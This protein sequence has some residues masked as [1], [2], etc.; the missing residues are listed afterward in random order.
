MRLPQT[1]LSAVIVILWAGIVTAVISQSAVPGNARVQ[2]AVLPGV[3]AALTNSD[4]AAVGLATLAENPLLDTAAQMKANDMLQN[5]YYAHTSPSGRSPFYW[6]D[7]VG[8]KYLNVG[9]NLDLVYSGTDATVNADWMNSV[10]HRTNILLP[11]FTETGS[12]VASG[13]YEGNQVTFV[14]ELFATP[15]P[16]VTEPPISPQVSPVVSKS[17]AIP[18]A[19]APV[20]NMPAPGTASSSARVVVPLTSVSVAVSTS[21][22]S[23]APAATSTAPV[24]T[25][26]IP[27]AFVPPST[28]S[29]PVAGTSTFRLGIAPLGINIPNL[30]DSEAYLRA[31]HTAFASLADTL[32][33]TLAHFGIVVPW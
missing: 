18:S 15:M 5:Q 33:H 24:V 21:A 8:Y 32:K 10:E 16:A 26:T 20:R 17:V 19:P 12:G 9:E 28:V 22:P 31:F 29:I 27:L 3:V 14:V 25:T 4:R 11:Q 6:L 13:L 23:R 30:L 7:Q 2:A 1:V